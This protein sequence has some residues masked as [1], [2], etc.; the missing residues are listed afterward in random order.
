MFLVYYIVKNG[1]P[2]KQDSCKKEEKEYKGE[3]P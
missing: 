1:S 2:M 3:Q